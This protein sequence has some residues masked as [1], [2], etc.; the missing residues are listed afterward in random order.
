[1][2]QEPLKREH[3]ELLDTYNA[4]TLSPETSVMVYRSRRRNVTEDLDV[5]FNLRR[6]LSEVHVVEK[7]V[8]RNQLPPV[9]YF[10]INFK[11][12]LVY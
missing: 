4:G 12:K 11:V 3:V 6:N 9:K 7:P 5:N 1:M 8:K 2:N 10:T